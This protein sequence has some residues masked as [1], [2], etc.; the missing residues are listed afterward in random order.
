MLY[1]FDS[2]GTKRI[3][4]LDLRGRHWISYTRKRLIIQIQISKSNILIM[5]IDMFVTFIA[6]WILTYAMNNE[7]IHMYIHVIF[8]TILRGCQWTLLCNQM[9]PECV[10]SAPSPGPASLCGSLVSVPSPG[11]R[12]SRSSRYC[13]D[14]CRSHET[15][16][17]AWGRSPAPASCCS[18][19][20]PSRPRP[21]ESA[22]ASP[23]RS[24]AQRLNF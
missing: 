11:S 19:E 18:C 6:R 12:C 10:I 9:L 16:G 8:V 4:Y 3:C 2:A 22:A 24:G 7:Y 21:P 17:R 5:L 23:V 13:R 1:D 15:S 20:A 14:W